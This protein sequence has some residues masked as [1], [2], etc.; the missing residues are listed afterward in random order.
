MLIFTPEMAN[1][2]VALKVAHSQPETMTIGALESIVS[3]VKSRYVV[4]TI[5]MPAHFSFWLIN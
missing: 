5:S 1:K 2:Q 3:I 4:L